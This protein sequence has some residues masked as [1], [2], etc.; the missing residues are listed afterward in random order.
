V[1]AILLVTALALPAAGTAQ[2]A[3]P[4]HAYRAAI[5][6][7]QTKQADA[8]MRA[9]ESWKPESV[10]RETLPLV[11]DRNPRL[12]PGVAL[13]MTELARRD[14]RSES[15]ERIAVAELLVR[16][17]RRDSPEIR[18]FQE[19]WYTFMVSVLTEELNPVGARP[20]IDRGLRLVGDSARLLL[21]SGLAFEMTTYPH[22]ACPTANCEPIGEQAAARNL[23]QAADAYRRATVLDPHLTEAHLRLGRVLHVLGDPGGARQELAEVERISS[24]ADTL[25]LAALFRS[26]LNQ[27]EGDLQ[28][29]AAEAER[30][31]SIAPEYP[32]ARIAL[33]HLSDRLGLFDRSRQI[34]NQLF[35]I[36]QAGDPWWQ[37]R[38][39]PQDFDSLDWMRVYSRQ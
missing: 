13:L 29:A 2:N 21:M 19:R 31:V 18:E 1:K 39:P 24:R 14:A 10:R 20:L 23:Q 30:A 17:L 38:Q 26:D 37:F 12:A 3:D 27:D 35:R 7:Y 16:S 4:L 5:I 25:Y 32:S 11:N 22:T 8:A 36:P 34:V 28:A 33:A 6:L 9:A 15:S